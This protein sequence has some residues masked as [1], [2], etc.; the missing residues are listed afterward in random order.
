M[1]GIRITIEDGTYNRESVSGEFTAIGPVKRGRK[2]L[3]VTVPGRDLGVVDAPDRACRILLTDDE[4]VAL[5]DGPLATAFLTDKQVTEK[6][7]QAEDKMVHT[8]ESDEKDLQRMREMFEVME[9]MM[10][11]MT[12]GH[13]KGL[14]AFG[15][16]GVGKSYEIV[17]GLNQAS[18]DC[19]LSDEPP[20][21][22][23]FSGF[24]TPVHLYKAL[25]SCKE[26]G[27][28]AVFD[29]CDNVLAEP[30][31]LNMLKVALDTTENRWLSYNAESYMLKEEEI[32][33]T[34]QFK[35]GIVFITNI[36]FENF[37]GKIHDHLQ[38]I[39]SRCHYLDLAINTKRDKLL[40][41][42]E[43]TLKKG[44]LQRKG[45]TLVQAQEIID[46]I[47]ENLDEMREL[48]LRMVLKIA[49]LRRIDFKDSKYDWRAKARVT[50][51]TRS[52]SGYLARQLS[53]AKA[54]RLEVHKVGG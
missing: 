30:D 49:D 31:S 22:K 41:M 33:S 53:E 12:E 5:R 20:R 15:P 45:L 16:P 17:N 36:D 13:I 24:M 9:E 32:D 37:R 23:V 47:E 8:E 44:M 46:F 42:K 21:H 25:W 43:V 52:G 51:M 40:W 27:Q 4:G 26:P 10:W 7:E 34:F 18:L 35:G 14:V 28:I 54:K 19:S 39:I 2:G 48:S 11:A 1:N 6:V 38:A 50:C 29:D 3:F